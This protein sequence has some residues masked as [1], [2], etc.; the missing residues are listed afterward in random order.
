MG[1]GSVLGEAVLKHALARSRT[2]WVRV[3]LDSVLAELV[4]YRRWIG[5]PEALCDL[6]GRNLFI[7]LEEDIEADGLVLTITG[8]DVV[9]H[10]LFCTWLVGTEPNC[11]SYYALWHR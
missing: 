1:C 9:A 10:G 7:L 4:D 5:D 11:I 8:F 6:P 3:D 2:P